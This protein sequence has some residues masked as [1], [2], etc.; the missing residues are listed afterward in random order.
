MS[1]ISVLLPFFIVALR[2]VIVAE[3]TSAYLS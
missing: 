2:R 1:R 3:K